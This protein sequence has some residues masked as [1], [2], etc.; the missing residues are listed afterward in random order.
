MP[1][2]SIDLVAWEAAL[3]ADH[4]ISAKAKRIAHTLAEHFR[5]GNGCCQLSAESIASESDMIAMGPVRDALASL[6]LSGWLA[7]EHV[8][9]T[10]KRGLVHRPLMAN[11]VQF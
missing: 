4:R 10:Q 9:D 7:S 3:R 6:R 1:A 11:D 2:E 5:Q 8:R